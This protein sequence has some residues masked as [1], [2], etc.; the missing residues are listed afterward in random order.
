MPSSSKAQKNVASVAGAKKSTTSSKSSNKNVSNKNETTT[1]VDSSA[2]DSSA[3]RKLVVWSL[4]A[5]GAFVV[6]RSAYNIRLFSIREY[7]PVIH[8][9]DPY[10]NYRASEVREKNGGIHP[11]RMAFFASREHENAFVGTHQTVLFVCSR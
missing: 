11:I 6:C 10:F 8:E 7:G 4:I 3:F 5:Y 2:N 1:T 9:F